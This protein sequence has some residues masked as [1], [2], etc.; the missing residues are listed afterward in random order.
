MRLLDL[1]CCQGGA[2]TGYHRAG[3]TDITGVDIR[4][5]PRYPFRFVQ[6]DALEFLRGVR[7]G[8]FDFIHASPPCQGF[9]TFAAMHRDRKEY[10]DLLTPTREVL[11]ALGT[12]YVIENVPRAPMRPDVV[13][14]GSHF[15]LPLRRH[16]WFEASLPL[17]G[18]L[19]ACRHSTSDFCIVGHGGGGGKGERVKRW[20]VE[21]GR[22][23]MG[24]EWMSQ[25]GLAEAIP[26]AYTEWI[27][28]QM[29]VVLEATRA[30]A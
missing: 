26:P 12:P 5:Q 6:A 4:P 13:L 7:P 1:F 22:R 8:E 10:P 2:A 29:L 3:F 14:C 16:R 20:R 30:A 19:P 24:I 25:H 17:F 21:D 23:A 11:E 28:R 15:G 9:S 27:G 18:L